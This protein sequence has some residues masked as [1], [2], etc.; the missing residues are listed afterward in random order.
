MYS[1]L[2]RWKKT[3]NEIKIAIIASF[4]GLSIFYRILKGSGIY[5]PARNMRTTTT[6]KVL[7]THCEKYQKLNYV[8]SS[9]A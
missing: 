6:K 1:M 3:P 2:F 4:P 5:S 8:L 7:E 9:F